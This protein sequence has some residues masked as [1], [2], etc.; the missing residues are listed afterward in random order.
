MVE[1]TNRHEMVE[2][3]TISVTSLRLKGVA[4]DT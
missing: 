1:H 2:A 3:V 4:L